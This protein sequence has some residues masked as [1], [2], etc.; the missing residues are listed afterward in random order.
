MYNVSEYSST[1]TKLRQRSSGCFSK[2]APGFPGAETATLA[3]TKMPYLPLYL[4]LQGIMETYFTMLAN[5]G[6]RRCP[7]REYKKATAV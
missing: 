6:K 1:S 7:V 3:Y 5:R 2:F 4:G